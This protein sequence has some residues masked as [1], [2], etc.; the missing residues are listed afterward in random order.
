[1]ITNIDVSQ[2]IITIDRLAALK[3]SLKHSR[4]HAMRSIQFW[5]PGFKGLRRE[6]VDKSNRLTQI[7]RQISYI[8][9]RKKDTSGI[10]KGNNK[11]R[12]NLE[13]ILNLIVS[14][15]SFTTQ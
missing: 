10:L 12:S 15:A 2:E 3:S 13:G 14:D 1:M 8:K 6:N 7:N 11:L 5:W 4:K 9:V